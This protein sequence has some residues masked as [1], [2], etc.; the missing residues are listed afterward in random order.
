MTTE[1]KKRTCTD[2]GREHTWEATDGRRRLQGMLL[3]KCST[4]G[5]WGWAPLAKPKL[6][7]AYKNAFADPM[8][9]RRPPPD[10]YTPRFGLN[11]WDRMPTGGGRRRQAQPRG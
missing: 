8:R 10:W 3:Y 11:D 2:E 4:C 1:T 7:R 5:A 6:T 9:T